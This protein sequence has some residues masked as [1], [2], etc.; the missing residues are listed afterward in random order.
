MVITKAGPAPKQWRVSIA[1]MK[2]KQVKH[3][4]FLAS[5]GTDLETNLS[6]DWGYIFGAAS[7]RYR[8]SNACGVVLLDLYLPFQ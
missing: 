3:S 8:F 6:N 5:K 2:R 7:G 4:T 1:P